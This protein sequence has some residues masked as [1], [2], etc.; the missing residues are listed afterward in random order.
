MKKILLLLIAVF[1]AVSACAAN[2]TLYLRMVEVVD[3]D[4]LFPMKIGM[5]IERP[6]TSIEEAEALR[7]E[8]IPQFDGKP[9]NDYIHYCYTDRPCVLEPLP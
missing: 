9:H 8:L 4:P 6:V 7:D 2:P 3:P 5:I 1:I